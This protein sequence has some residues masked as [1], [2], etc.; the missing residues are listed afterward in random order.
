MSKF[1]EVFTSTARYI[2]QRFKSILDIGEKLTVILAAIAASYFFVLRKDNS[3][4]LNLKVDAALS[5]DCVIAARL[6]LE[7]PKGLP[8]EPQSASLQVYSL[9]LRETVSSPNNDLR[10]A[11]QV[12]KL[13]DLVKIGERF[14]VV[15][16]VRLPEPQAEGDILK[17]RAQISLPDSTVY[18]EEE[19]LETKE[20]SV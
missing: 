16:A 10:L 14:S 11:E 2:R 17:L 19:F 3:S 18:N 4:H 8:L 7:N 6:A 1:F 9:D 20:C 13:I 5:S 15:L 12:I